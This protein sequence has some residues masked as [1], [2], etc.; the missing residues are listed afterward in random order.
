MFQ[1]IANKAY[2]DGA[3]GYYDGKVQ[4]PY[5]RYARNSVDNFKNYLAAFNY[6]VIEFTPEG[7]E[8]QPK[9][10]VFEHSTEDDT[11]TEGTVL[12]FG[13]ETPPLEY[14]HRYLPHAS[15]Y[16]FI[17]KNALMGAAY[18]EMNEQKAVPVRVL[19]QNLQEVSDAAYGEN[20]V[21][22][23][24]AVLDLNNDGVIDLAE[25]STTILLED[26]LSKD[27]SFFRPEN[28]DGSITDTGENAG[29]EYMEADNYAFSRTVLKKIYKM[30]NLGRAQ[31]AFLSDENNITS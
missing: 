31:E 30:F 10:D 27:D 25:F 2:I 14:E 8:R 12:I 16:R 13:D 9:E 6:T 11:E 7:L 26:A 29:L 28:I 19:S 3:K 4:N 5:V 18:E 21:L 1:I 15:N 17:N 20:E 24:A 22:M 23:D